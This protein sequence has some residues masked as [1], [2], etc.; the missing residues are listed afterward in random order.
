MGTLRL[1]LALSV[2][3]GH[4]GDFLGFNL[5]PGDTAVQAFY[6]VSGFYMTLVLNE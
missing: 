4:A 5:V 3:Y 2:V 1:I 6:A